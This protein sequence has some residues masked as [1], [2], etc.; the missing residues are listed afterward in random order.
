MKNKKLNRQISIKERQSKLKKSSEKKSHQHHHSSSI[1]SM[2]NLKSLII[3]SILFLIT[4]LLGFIFIK[5]IFENISLDK[6]IEEK[7][8][9]LQKGEDSRIV[10][11]SEVNKLE[12][13]VK[14][15]EIRYNKQKQEEEK[16]LEL[17]NIEKI[18]LRSNEDTIKYYDKLF[19]DQNQRLINEKNLMKSN[20]IAIDN[21]N[22][23]IQKLIESN[24]KI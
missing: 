10:T 9:S 11:I 15:T 3:L 23:R 21:L 17:L 13:N 18:N 16:Y 22:K 4:F 14:R 5:K 20:K 12:T 1:F 7:K 2:Y 24:K 19:E 8:I 6:Q